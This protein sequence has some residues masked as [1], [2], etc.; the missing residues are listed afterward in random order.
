VLSQKEARCLGGWRRLREE[1]NVEILT[2]GSW[3]YSQK[4]G[5]TT[6]DRRSVDPEGCFAKIWRTG[7]WI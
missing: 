4:R 2:D 7:H 6:G 5:W 3:G 1:G